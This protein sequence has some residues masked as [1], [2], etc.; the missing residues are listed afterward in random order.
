MTYVR[1]HGRGPADPGHGSDVRGVVDAPRGRGRTRGRPAAEGTDIRVLGTGQGT[2]SVR[3]QHAE[4]GR[5]AWL[6]RPAAGPGAG[7]VRPGDQRPGVGD[8]DAAA[9]V[10]RGGHRLPPRAMAA[11]V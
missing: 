4:V 7:A 11:A 5:R 10:A 2:G 8:G 9:V 3:H 1:T 6:Q